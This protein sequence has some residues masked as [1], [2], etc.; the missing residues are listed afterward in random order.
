MGMRSGGGEVKKK[1]TRG[2]KKNKKKRKKKV[3]DAPCHNCSS[4][5]KAREESSGS[6]VLLAMMARNDD[7]YPKRQRYVNH[8][9]RITDG[10]GWSS[11]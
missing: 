1:R 4:L 6:K 3:A 5:S 9:I 11:G 7:G 10:V 2:K 8:K